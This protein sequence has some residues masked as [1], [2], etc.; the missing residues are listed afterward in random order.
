MS[1]FKATKDVNFIDWHTL[2]VGLQHG[3]CQKID[4]IKF[5]ENALRHDNGELINIVTGESISEKEL[6]ST[7]FRFIEKKG[8]PLSQEKKEEAVEK[9]RF[10]Y[11]SSL[12]ESQESDSKKIDDL[13]EIY[14]EFGFPDDMASCSVY[15][16]DNIDPFYAAKSVVRT[17]AQ[18]CKS[19]KSHKSIN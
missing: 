14:S 9:W 2:I 16:G 7:C 17:L 19:L 6:I 1:A 13:Q 18:K 10:A 5:A 3:W 15:K 12:L 8:M 4:V 11:L